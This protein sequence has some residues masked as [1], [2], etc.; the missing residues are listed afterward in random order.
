MEQWQRVAIVGTPDQIMSR[1]EH[2][3]SLGFGYII[4]YFS[5]ATWGDGMRLFGNDVIPAMR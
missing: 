2:A 3:A 1:I 4:L 5:D